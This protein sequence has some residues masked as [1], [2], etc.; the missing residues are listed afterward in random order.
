MLKLLKVADTDLSLKRWLAFK[1]RKTRAN[2]KNFEGSSP[3]RL[4][5]VL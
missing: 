4:F 5:I 1:D 2:V 3:F